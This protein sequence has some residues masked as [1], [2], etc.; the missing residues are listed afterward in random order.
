MKGQNASKLDSAKNTLTV[1][2]SCGQCQFGLKG[3]GC[4]LAVRID[5]QAYYVKGTDIDAYGD[6]HS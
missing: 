6:A 4:R 1:V 3:K 5:G 2:A